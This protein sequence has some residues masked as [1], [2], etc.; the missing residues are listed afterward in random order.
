MPHFFCYTALF[1]DLTEAKPENYG[2]FSFVAKCYGF[3]FLTDL[4]L[5][6]F[7]VL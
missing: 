7:Q 5:N 6:I 1:K 2:F 4:S 3:L